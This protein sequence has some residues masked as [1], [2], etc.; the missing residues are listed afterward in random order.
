M[1][2]IAVLDDMNDWQKIRDLRNAATHDYTESDEIKAQ[3][4]EQLLQRADFLYAVLGKL[5][6]FISSTYP[7]NSRKEL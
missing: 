6:Q 5:K 4:F 1:V 7:E 2:Q 3:H